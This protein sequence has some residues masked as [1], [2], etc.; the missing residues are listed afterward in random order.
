MG[1]IVGRF[2]GVEAVAVDE[3]TVDVEERWTSGGTVGTV[4]N[5]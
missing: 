1:A 3:V 5:A 4:G 2:W